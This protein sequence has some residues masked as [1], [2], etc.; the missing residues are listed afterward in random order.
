MVLFSQD[1]RR[2]EVKSEPWEI[3]MMEKSLNLERKQVE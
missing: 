2:L 1:M 3:G